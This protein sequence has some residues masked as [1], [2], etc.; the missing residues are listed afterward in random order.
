M[1][2]RR[3]LSTA[4]AA[5]LLACCASGSKDADWPMYNRDVPG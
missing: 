1:N 3:L 4:P 5:V 2:S